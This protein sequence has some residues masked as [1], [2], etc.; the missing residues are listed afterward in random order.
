MRGRKIKKEEMGLSFKEIWTFLLHHYTIVLKG[1]SI[2]HES[3]FFDSCFNSIFLLILQVQHVSV[4]FACLYSYRI[5]LC[6]ILGPQPEV[7]LPTDTGTILAIYQSIY[8]SYELNTSYFFLF[9]L[10][11]F[12]PGSQDHWFTHPGEPQWIWRLRRL[13]YMQ[14]QV[15][16][17]LSRMLDYMCVLCWHVVI[18]W[19]G[20]LSSKSSD[21]LCCVGTVV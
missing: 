17:P 12:T 21:V 10:F 20:A 1:Q 11:S 5:I 18:L 15:Q 9:C 7:H 2:T 8:L 4:H 6:L 13:I 14:I 3:S 16:W 19:E